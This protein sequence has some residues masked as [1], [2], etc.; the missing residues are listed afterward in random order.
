MLYAVR[1]FVPHAKLAAA[2]AAI[3][4]S[5]AVA[6]T[7]AVPSAQAAPEACGW[8]YGPLKTADPGLVE[9]GFSNKTCAYTV[10]VWVDVAGP[11]PDSP[12]MYVRTGE[13]RGWLYPEFLSAVV[14]FCEPLP[15]AS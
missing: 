3:A 8:P 6:L 10:G 15:P 1:R 12:C 4:C 13:R 7:L 11:Y 9:S 2:L 14:R 5:A